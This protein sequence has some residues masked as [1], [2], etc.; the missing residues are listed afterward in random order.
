[1]I[2]LSQPLQIHSFPSC[3]NS[4]DGRTLSE[5]DWEKL[6]SDIGKLNEDLD[7]VDLRPESEVEQA[8]PSMA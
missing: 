2:E 4:G 7:R 5:E 6:R 3:F 1:M 8:P